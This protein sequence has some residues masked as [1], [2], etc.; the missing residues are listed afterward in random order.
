M[1]TAEAWAAEAGTVAGTPNSGTAMI[2]GRR[3]GSWPCSGSWAC[4][5]L[6]SAA[7]TVSSLPWSLSWA[8]GRTRLGPGPAANC[9][10]RSRS[11]AE[12]F[13]VLA[14]GGCPLGP[15]CATGSG[16]RSSRH[17]TTLSDPTWTG[18]S[19]APAASVGTV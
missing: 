7:D 2:A 5:A 10:A 8:A 6:A 17:T 11:A 14:A 12:S 3:A 1:D 16:P 19:A 9:S 18:G 4:T 15:C 13:R